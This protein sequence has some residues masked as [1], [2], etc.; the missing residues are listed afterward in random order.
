[1]KRAAVAVPTIVLLLVLVLLVFTPSGTE[2]TEP[3]RVTY[4]G[5]C[6]DV[7]GGER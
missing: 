6:G 2:T 5:G 3:A 1:M 7:W 4:G